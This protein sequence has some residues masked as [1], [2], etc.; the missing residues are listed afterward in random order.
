MVGC[1]IGLK[2]VDANLTAFVEI[3]AGLGTGWLGVAGSA[4][5]FAAEEF[6]AAFRRSFIKTPF[7]WF[8]GWDR[9]LIKMQRGELGRDQVNIVVHVTESIPGSN[10][11][12][13]SVVQPG[14]KE[15]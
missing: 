7:G 14:I 1:P 9:Q 8:R 3:P 5:G 2:V 6:V 13:R 11:K 15:V 12:L 4:L 10:R